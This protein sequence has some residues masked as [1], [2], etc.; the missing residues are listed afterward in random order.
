[1]PFRHLSIRAKLMLSMGVCLLVFIAISSALSVMLTSSRMRERVVGNEMPAQV[2]AIRNDIQ[3]QIAEPAAM[4]RALANN[5]FL[6][7]WEEDGVPESG[8]PAWQQLAARLKETSHA[9]IVFWA[10]D[11]GSKYFNENGFDRALDKASAQDAWLG[12]FLAS[13]QP[14]SL[15]LSKNPGA[16]AY[17]LFINARVETAHG[18]LA[19]AGLGLS[20]DALANSIR[21]Y[22]LGQSGFVYLVGENGT[23]LVH[24]DHQLLD[25]K[26]TLAALPGFSAGLATQL[27]GRQPFAASAYDAPS[28]RQLVASSWVP[29]LKLYVVAEVP[30]AEVLGNIGRSAVLSSLTAALVG[31]A[32]GLAAIWFVARAISAPVMGA[33]GMLGEIADGEGDLSRRMLV[34]SED[35]VGKLAQAFNRFVG[36]L[37]GTIGQVRASS[38]VIA[39][40]SDEIARGNLDLSSRTENQASSVEETAAAMEELTTAV[41]RNAERASEARDMVAASTRSA[42]QGGAVVSE[43]MRT[44]GAISD[45]SR[46]MSEIIGVIDGIAFQT[47]ILALNAAV[48]AAR[49]GEQGRGFAVVA[50]EVRNL[51]QRS[52]TAAKEI[53][54]LILDSVARVDSGSTLAHDAGQAM[55]EIVASVRCA[56]D[57]MQEI[58]AS[59]HEQSAG[60]AQVNQAIAQ[61]DDATQQNAALVEQAAAAA[62]SLQEQAREL[63]RV[64]GT[65]KLAAAGQAPAASAASASETRLRLQA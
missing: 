56:Q 51:A 30:E 15:N 42:E 61:M 54:Q 37:A 34:A 3:R 10:S 38:S 33:A 23:L 4:S 43:V 20:A 63:D 47:N 7:A 8:L 57:L 24:R 55:E 41:R 22:R 60:I 27:L 9:A 35:E 6:H 52:G 39:G 31:G 12:E 64:V 44:M 65:F 40:A 58:A 28:G 19:V 29:E 26:H 25:G 62:A 36:S 50:S 16:D 13:R 2:A 59:S 18:K 48:E 21:N 11:T 46:K 32:I 53:R 5:T 17:M 14:Y 1:M 49:A 45:S